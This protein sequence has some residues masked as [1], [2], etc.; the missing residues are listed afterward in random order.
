M[1]NLEYIN[2]W[3]IFLYGKSYIKEPEPQPILTIV[4]YSLEKFGYFTYITTISDLYKLTDQKKF[5]SL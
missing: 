2:E 4:F 3:V 1:S 5:E